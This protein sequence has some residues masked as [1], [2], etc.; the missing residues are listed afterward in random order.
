MNTF[1]APREE[2]SHSSVV[3]SLKGA[4]HLFYWEYLIDSKVTVAVSIPFPFIPP[5]NISGNA[6]LMTIEANIF[7][8]HLEHLD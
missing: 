1:V 7:G 6:V 3:Q 8:T 5:S 4:Q 2:A